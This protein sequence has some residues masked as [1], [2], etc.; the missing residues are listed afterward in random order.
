VYHFVLVAPPS[1][2]A[3]I[4]TRIHVPGGVSAFH[5]DTSSLKPKPVANQEDVQ[6]AYEY[7]RLG[8]P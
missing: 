3:C 1:P 6:R 7:V 8:D 2:E 5:E 4:S